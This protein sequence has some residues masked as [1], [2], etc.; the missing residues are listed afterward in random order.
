M[1]IFNFLQTPKIRRFHHECI[2]Y[3]PQKE[4]RLEREERIR[5]K[6]EAEEKGELYVEP[7]KKGV[8]KSQLKSSTTI[9]QAKR[10]KMYIT[11]LMIG[12]LIYM[13]SR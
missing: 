13:L 8:F 10:L 1:A 7:L 3:D 9:L 2:Y 4:A 6:R 11:L 5:K 12:A